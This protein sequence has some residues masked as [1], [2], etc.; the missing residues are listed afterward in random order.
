MAAFVLMAAIVLMCILAIRMLQRVLSKRTMRMD[1]PTIHQP[2]VCHGTMA[3]CTVDEPDL[4]EAC[5]RDSAQNT[6]SMETTDGAVCMTW[7]ESC[8]GEPF[9]A[10]YK[11]CSKVLD[12]YTEP[13][14]LVHNWQKCNLLSMH[15]QLDTLIKDASAIAE[16]GLVNRV[17]FVLDCSPW[18]RATISAGLGLLCPV[19]P[20]RVFVDAKTARK[21]ASDSHAAVW[22]AV[23]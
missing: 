19:Q 12:A 13:F 16:H 23:R 4:S 8:T 3:M 1:A 14:T 22:Q 9:V 20:A 10:S 5:S 15:G 7:P 21:W 6:I 2:D 11:H 17:A 18:L